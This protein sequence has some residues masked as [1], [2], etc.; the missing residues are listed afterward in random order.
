MVL[1]DIVGSMF[2]KAFMEELLKPQDLYSLRA[3]RCVITRLAHTSIMR[4]NPTS[5][6]RLYDLIVMA[7]KH[8]VLLCPRPRDLLLITFNH[9][10]AIREI[11][12]SSPCLIHQINE[13]Q[14]QI[15]EMFTPLSDGEFQLIRQTLLTLLQDMHIKVS[16]FMKEKIQN[17]DGRFVLS[18]SGPVPHGSEVPGLIRWFNS[19]GREVRRR[20]FPNEGCYCSPVKEGSFDISG[21]RVTRLGTNMYNA[22]SPEDT[23]T[24][25]ASRTPKVKQSVEPNPLAKEELNLLAK[26]MGGMEVWNMASGDG[27]VRMNLF[28][29]E[30]DEDE[31]YDTYRINH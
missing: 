25:N 27:G 12:R 24:S 14:R 8:Q 11:V 16:I 20:E 19:R 3:L 21:E 28:L 26:L 2:S 9:V 29:S 17:P 23:R 22:S 15:I 5:M 13:A 10:D 7:F 18:T 4:L 30:Q 31:G 1:S 6:D